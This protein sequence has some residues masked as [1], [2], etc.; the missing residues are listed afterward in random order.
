MRHGAKITIKQ[1][2][3][4]VPEAQE[5][6]KCSRGATFLAPPTRPA[7]ASRPHGAYC[8]PPAARS[9]RIG[10]QRSPRGDAHHPHPARK[11]T[12]RA[13]HC[14]SAEPTRSRAG[15]Q[16]A[17]SSVVACIR[18]APGG[19]E[20]CHAVDKK[21]HLT[22][23]RI[24]AGDPSLGAGAC[25]GGVRAPV[26]AVLDTWPP[27]SVAP[28]AILE[29]EHLHQGAHPVSGKFESHPSQ[30]A[31]LGRVVG[32]GPRWRRAARPVPCLY[33]AQAGHGAPAAHDTMRAS[34]LAPYKHG[35]GRA[36]RRRRRPRWTLSGGDATNW[37]SQM[38]K[39][40]NPY[41]IPDARGP[42]GLRTAQRAKTV[43]RISSSSLVPFYL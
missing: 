17:W 25:G 1:P 8:I 4:A 14:Q 37:R 20:S 29:A 28:P 12:G 32:G 6:C 35:T 23:A 11:R 41:G 40:K 34:P 33:G 31:H 38:E 7:R 3:H 27:Q 10:P 42:S 19:K 30:M 26:H 21:L 13:P 24:V 9:H 5:I 36:A 15:A 18:S 39:E 16:P 22:R 43:H 2:L